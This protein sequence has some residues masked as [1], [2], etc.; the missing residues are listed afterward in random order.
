M[1][2]N[3]EYNSPV[4]GKVQPFEYS[5]ATTNEYAFTYDRDISSDLSKY[6]API[7]VARKRRGFFTYN[8]N[9]FVNRVSSKKEIRLNKMQ[10]D[11][12]PTSRDVIIEDSIRTVD[13]KNRAITQRNS[14]ILR[15]LFIKEYTHNL[16]LYT[17][18]FVKT[19]IPKIITL[20]N[21]KSVMKYFSLETYD[22]Y[23]LEEITSNSLYLYREY[24]AREKDIGQISIEDTIFLMKPQWELFMHHS[25][26]FFKRKINTISV[27]KNNIATKT[28]KE[29][30]LYKELRINHKFE[31][32]NVNLYTSDSLTRTQ[33]SVLSVYESVS[34][35]RINSSKIFL[36]KSITWMMPGNKCIAKIDNLFLYKINTNKACHANKLYSL[37]KYKKRMVKSRD[38]VLGYHP[39]RKICFR[40]EN[41]FTY[42][43]DKDLFVKSNIFLS[44][45]RHGFVI[46]QDNLYS[47]KDRFSFGINAEEVFTKKRKKGFAINETE[48]MY[49]KD[50]H[51]FTILETSDNIFKDRYNLS[52]RYDLLVNKDSSGFIIGDS[53]ESMYKDRY[54]TS[55]IVSEANMDEIGILTTM[56]I[57]SNTL[58]FIVSTNDVNLN[59]NLV[60]SKS[61]KNL[62][63][64]E[65]ESFVQKEKNNSLY[66]SFSIFAFPEEKE[67]V[68]NQYH[69]MMASL[70]LKDML[71]F[72][73]QEFIAKDNKT[74]IIYDSKINV[75]KDIKKGFVVNTKLVISKLYK[76]TLLEENMAIIDKA[77]KTTFLY[78]T[79]ES[80]YKTKT[81]TNIELKY[82][83][84]KTKVRV[85]ELFIQQNV[86]KQMFEAFVYDNDIHVDKA[87]ISIIK[88]NSTEWIEKEKERIIDANSMTGIKKERTSF[89]PT[90]NYVFIS[91]EKYEF[92]PVVS[93]LNSMKKIIKELEKPVEK[94]YNWA[95]VYQYDDPIDPNYDIYGIDE[96]LL[97]EKDINYGTFEDVIF[98]KKTMK[99]KKPIK[100]IDDNTFIAKYPTKHPIPDYEKIG[101]EYIDIETELMY[102]LF[103][104][105]YQ[106]WYANIFKFGNMS[107]VDSLRLMLDYM[108]A[109]IVTVYGGSVYL[110]QALRIFRLIRWF[111]ETSVMHNA[112]YRVTCEYQDLKS[113]LHTG[114]C[115]I[116][117]MLNGFSVN[118]ELKVL[119]SIP[120]MFGS[121]A[122]IKLYVENKEDTKITFSI[123]FTG[124]EVEV[125][126][127]GEL[128]DVISSNRGSI[129]YDIP[130]NDEENELIIRRAASSNIGYCYVGNIIVKNGTYK[131][132]NIEYDPELKAGN[133]PLNDVV[134]K[135][136]LLANMYDNE[137]EV[138][139][140]Y[141]KGNLGIS[142]LYKRLTDYWELHH[143]NKIKGKRLT[144]KET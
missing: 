133:L 48:D 139:A 3:F 62:F 11:I 20:H 18:G 87:L 60:I 101:I 25:A 92:N 105:F 96:L 35:K 66:N 104:K 74:A 10:E 46:N 106:I 38:I 136:V 100:I 67:I 44:K 29:M 27:W 120:A 50:R 83:W 114:K 42:K 4:I 30:F 132:L 59:N 36:D 73:V 131:N 1:N 69:S 57:H 75:I 32:E 110:E 58:G 124:G 143:A 49:K 19:Y 135:M 127:N 9:L 70:K 82:V 55:L 123:S 109:H 138:F 90:E 116:K 17:G 56:D 128:I 40:K 52:I 22:N 94:T 125:I 78:D 88:D 144:I 119:S 111:G 108:Y 141:R 28:K 137:Q 71:M 37:A 2:Y 54:L 24:H 134:N 89:E 112:Q 53:S 5:Y 85:S 47:Y 43:Y 13:V 16:D 80:L 12:K 122:Y 26:Y 93:Q 45:D 81:Q 91:K 95:Y 98:D 84:M 99:P 23:F 21:F 79:N 39:K 77:N 8:K 129:T 33:P 107:M 86:N 68:L 102:K 118:K 113:D 65:T 34:A 97:P 31:K 142:E 61:G 121:E 117:N 72:A 64:K 126:L 6:N 7:F 103:I 15:E 14:G 63:E 51:G 130:E 115:K 41:L 76:H 140:Q